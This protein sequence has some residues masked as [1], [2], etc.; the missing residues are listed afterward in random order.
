[1]I[2]KRSGTFFPFL[3]QKNARNRNTA[4]HR[5]DDRG[6]IIPS[7]KTSSYF[8][9]NISHYVPACWAE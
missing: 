1:L 8:G 9:K 3:G 2:A 5:L 6:N 7:G 4:T